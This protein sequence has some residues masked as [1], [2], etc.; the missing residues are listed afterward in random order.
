LLDEAQ[1]DAEAGSAH[2]LADEARVIRSAGTAEA[3]AIGAVLTR[4]FPAS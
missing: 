4:R 2:A 1:A 3:D